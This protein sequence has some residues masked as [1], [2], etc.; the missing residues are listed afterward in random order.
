MAESSAARAEAI[1]RLGDVPALGQHTDEIRREFAPYIAGLAVIGI[2]Y[3]V[4]AAAACSA[5]CG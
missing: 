2:V 4:S 1:R 5:S 3:A